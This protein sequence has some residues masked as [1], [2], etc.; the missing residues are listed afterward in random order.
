MLYGFNVVAT[1]HTFSIIAVVHLTEMD[2]KAF[3]Q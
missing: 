1:I 3:I 2:G